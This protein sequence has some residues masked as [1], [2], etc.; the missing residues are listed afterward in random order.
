MEKPNIVLVV[1]DTFRADH[2]P[3]YGNS[4]IIAP[5]LTALAESSLVFDNAYA[6]SFP[7]VPAR[8]DL[9][10]GKYTFTFMGWE[11]L[12]LKEITLAACLTDAGLLTTGIVDTPF[13][14]R[15]GYGYDRGFQDFLWIRGQ[16]SGPE[17]DDVVFN[18]DKEE[19]YFAPQTFKTA[20]DWLERHQKEH[21]FLYIDT[22]D[23]HEPWDPPAHY[24]KPY[25][26]DYAGEVV[27]PNY[28]GWKEDHFTEKDLAIAH[29][30]YCGEISMVDHWFGLFMDRLASLGIAENTI[31][32]F[33]SDHGFYFGEHDLFGKTRFRWPGNVG[34]EEGFIK[35]YK[36]GDQFSYRSPLHRE[37]SHIPLIIHIPGVE[38]RRLNALAS[39][40]DLMPTILQ[41]ANAP[42]PDSVRAKSLL[43]LIVGSQKKI[44]DLVVTSGSLEPIGVIQKI[45]DDQPRKVVQ[46]SPST[47]T[48]EEFDLLYSVEGEPVE[49]YDAKAD[50]QH[51]HDLAAE[52]REIVAI[53]HQMYV[54]WLQEMGTPEDRLTKRLKL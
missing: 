24:V 43:P 46:L 40:P 37:V 54:L 51:L 32:I 19:Q 6:A 16:R 25:Y 13:L 45:V 3:C 17:H 38:P 7:T 42:I 50:P 44:H 41:L 18:R 11:P 22:W 14:V 1:S 28:W 21:F 52:K 39:T 31:V 4:S 47:I 15:N 48:T 9:M 49:L 26:P 10:T 2:L 36:M 35:G 23:P 5:N 29:A 12:P 27:N 30:C 53:L 20:V 34:F 33:T 8:A